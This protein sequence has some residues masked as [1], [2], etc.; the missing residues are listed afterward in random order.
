MV[1]ISG[2]WDNFK[3][4]LQNDTKIL[5][6]GKNMTF[7]VSCFRWK[8]QFRHIGISKTVILKMLRNWL[9]LAKEILV[10]LNSMAVNLYNDKG[11]LRDR[12]KPSDQC[13]LRDWRKKRFFFGCVAGGVAVL[14]FSHLCG[15]GA[16][17]NASCIW[18]R[19]GRNNNSVWMECCSLGW[20]S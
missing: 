16:R 7:S 4:W 13:C 1:A 8:W 9:V 18:K 14:S 19:V 2:R 12:D 10:T 5:S 3:G 6:I 15:R 11:E 17:G 20:A